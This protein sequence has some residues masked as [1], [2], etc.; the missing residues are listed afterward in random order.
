VLD[1]ITKSK[2]PKVTFGD[3]SGWVK[4]PEMAV[5][6]KTRCFFV[7]KTSSRHEAACIIIPGPMILRG[8]QNSARGCFPN[9]RVGA[10]NQ[11]FRG[12]RAVAVHQF[13]NLLEFF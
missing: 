13:L 9:E 5:F 12:Q 4:M 11:I 3:K 6:C 7:Q 8:L 10:L 1:I 2:F